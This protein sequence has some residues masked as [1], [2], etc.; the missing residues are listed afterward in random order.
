LDVLIDAYALARPIGSRLVIVGGG[1][2]WQTLRDRAPAD[3]LMPGFVERPQDWFSA[4]DGF[5]SAARSE[6]FGLVF[7]EAFASGLPVLATASQGAQM[8]ESLIG[9]TLL[10]CGD[11]ASMSEGLQVFAEGRPQR[12]KYNLTPYDYANQVNAIENFYASQLGF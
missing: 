12:K 11:V 9:R 7:L 5:V 1:R 8:F 2:D 10:P 6:P 4:F 3:V